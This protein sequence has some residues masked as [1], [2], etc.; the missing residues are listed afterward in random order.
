MHI[1]LMALV[2]L[3]FTVTGCAAYDGN[4]RGGGYERDY[5]PRYEP[6]RYPVYGAAP[7]YPIEVYRAPPIRTYQPLP[8]PPGYRPPGQ[9]RPAPPPPAHYEQR[10]FGRSGSSGQHSWGSQRR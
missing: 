1:Q 10:G 4:Y 9:Y 2:L 3:V 6:P 5:P 7:R 8:P